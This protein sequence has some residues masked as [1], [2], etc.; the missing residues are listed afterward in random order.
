MSETKSF[1]ELFLSEY[2]EEIFKVNHLKILLLNN[3]NSNYM[4]LIKLKEWQVEHQEYFDYVFF[5]GNFLSNSDNNNKN[6]LKVISNDEAEI[7]GLISF[8]EN[9]SLNVI[10]VGG[11]NDTPT[12][13]KTPCPTLTLRSINLHNNYHKL[14]EDLYLIGYGQNIF[15]NI[16]DNSLENTFSSFHEYTKTNNITN[17]QTILLYDTLNGKDI[18]SNKSKKIYEKVINNDKNHIFLNINGNFSTE[19]GTKK[20]NNTTIVN[21]GSICKGEFGILIIERDIKNNNCWKIQK[22]DYLT[23]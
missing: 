4:Y 1:E 16:C 19:K 18:L 17:F 15:M 13:F 5:S 3:I 6:D 2:K 8:L 12:I 23:I 7:G 21:P 11:N 10:Y 14:A 9:L 20:I 22:I